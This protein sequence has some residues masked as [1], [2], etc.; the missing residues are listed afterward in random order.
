MKWLY[1]GKEIIDKKLKGSGDEVI[2]QVDFYVYLGRFT[3]A[4][5]SVK[6]KL[7]EK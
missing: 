2:E 3:S 1:P 7:K 6:D 4:V 5:S